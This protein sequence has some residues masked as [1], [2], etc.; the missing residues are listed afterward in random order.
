MKKGLLIISMLAATNLFAGVPLLVSHGKIGRWRNDSVITYRVDQGSLGSFSNS[1]ATALVAGA[2]SVWQSV[3]SC[4]LTVVNG[5][6]IGYDVNASTWS[7][8][9]SQKDNDPSFSPVVFDND[10]SITELYYGAGASKSI[11]G[12]AGPSHMVST[13]DGLQITSGWAVLNGQLANQTQAIRNQLWRDTLV[14]EFGHFLN[15]SHSPANLALGQDSDLSNNV[16]IPV[17]SPVAWLRPQGWSG[18]AADDVASISSLYPRGNFK[19]VTGTLSGHITL[20]DGSPFKGAHVAAIR[21]G[22]DQKPTTEVYSGISG[23]LDADNTQPDKTGYFEITGVPA[24]QYAIHIEDLDSRY[25]W[26]VAGPELPG[27][28]EFFNSADTGSGDPDHF[29]VVTVASGQTVSNLNVALNSGP[30]YRYLSYLPLSISTDSWSP[31]LGILNLSSQAGLASIEFHNPD[32]SI[33]GLTNTTLAASGLFLLRDANRKLTGKSGIIGYILVRASQPVSS[34]I[35]L[36]TTIGDPQ[37]LSGLNLDSASSNSVPGLGSHIMIPFA[38]KL[39][40]WRTHLA[41]L[42][43]GP[44]ATITVDYIGENGTALASRTYTINKDCLTYV[45]DIVAAVPNTDGYLAITSGDPQSKL[46]VNG[47]ITSADKF[48]GV[49]NPVLLTATSSN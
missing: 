32:G 2:F 42:N 18:T 23:F 20:A 31:T 33:G 24:G 43:L 37:I 17:M 40:D 26:I 39:G 44:A 47:L 9:Q 45:Q 34:W 5:G 10:G 48:G 3:P 11:L 29:S 46:L 16:D 30:S 22:A 13:T 28:P 35:S 1:D 38:A 36:A 7:T 41:I 15:L 49:L 27:P 8:F 12:F 19:M 4:N 6:S 25:S 14:H 21:L